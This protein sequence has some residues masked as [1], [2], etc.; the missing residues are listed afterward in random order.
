VEEFI[1]RAGK[2]KGLPASTVDN[3]GGKI[4][5]F[6]SYALGVYDPTSDID[7]LVVAPRHIH[8]DDFFQHFPPTF[9]E[10]SDAK[11]ITEFNPVE[12]THVPIIKME[13]AGVSIDLLFASLPTMSTIPKDLSLLDRSLLRGMDDTGMRSMNGPRVIAEML[14]SV[15]QLKSFRH[16]LRA[17][18]LWANRGSPDILLQFCANLTQDEQSTGLSSDTLA[19]LHGQSWWLVSVS[20]IRLLVEPQFFQSSSA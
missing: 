14:E 2:A 9:R 18:K 10:M 7:T 17:I 20:S 3:S 15:P 8:M 12:D 13:Y 5:T 4:F 1:R 19:E 11:D 16:A 6:G